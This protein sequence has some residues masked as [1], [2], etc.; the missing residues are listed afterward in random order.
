MPQ[1][2]SFRRDTSLEGDERVKKRI[3]TYRGKRVHHQEAGWEDDMVPPA[4]SE[5]AGESPNRILL[6]RKIGKRRP[7]EERGYKPIVI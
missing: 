1:N 6:P 2:R 3:A 7:E 4:M 5:G